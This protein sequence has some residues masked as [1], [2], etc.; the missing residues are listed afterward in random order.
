[1]HTDATLFKMGLHSSMVADTEVCLV[2]VH[3]HPS[4]AL[5]TD[6]TLHLHKRVTLHTHVALHIY[7]IKHTDARL[8]FGKVLNSH[9]VRD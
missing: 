1:M 6:V 2:S 9:R 4:V 5:H 3:A 8:L 7:V